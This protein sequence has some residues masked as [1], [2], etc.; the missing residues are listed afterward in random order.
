[1]EDSAT[2]REAVA[3]EFRSDPDFEIVGEAASLSEARGVLATAD[4]VILDLGLP[5]GSGVELICELRDANPE[6]RAIVLTSAFDPALHARAIESGAAAVLDKITQLGQVAQAVRR[7]LD[8]SEPVARKRAVTCLRV[9]FDSDLP[10]VR[11]GPLFHALRREHPGVVLDWHAVGFPVQGRSLLDGADIGVFVH[12]PAEVGVRALTLDASQMV[13]VMAVGHRLAHQDTLSVADVLDEPFPGGPHL[14]PEWSAFWT[15]DDQRGRPPA[16]T[17]DEVTSAEHGLQAVVTGR[18]IATVPDWV[19]SGL[20]HP[21]VVAVPLKD[22]PTV[23]TCMV[24]RD[25]EENPVVLRLVELATAWAR[26]RQV[27]ATPDIGS[28][29][30]PARSA[31]LPYAGPAPAPSRSPASRAA[32]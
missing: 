27:D 2:V 28:Q 22:G 23:T 4:V 3:S 19:A 29:P 26:D 24:W 11:W 30:A 25:N 9:A 17:D 15:L 10:H 13:V 8:L 12:P 18:A 20:A 32:R 16:R 14:R 6:A 5:D 31:S 7:I 21:G 1:V